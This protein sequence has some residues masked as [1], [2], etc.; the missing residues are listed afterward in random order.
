M[1]APNIKGVP[2]RD[3]A[4]F[5][6]ASRIMKSGK[7]PI[8][9]Y[10]D[11]KQIHKKEEF[12]FHKYHMEADLMRKTFGLGRSSF[13]AAMQKARLEQSL[14]KGVP[15]NQL[16]YNPLTILDNQENERDPLFG[17]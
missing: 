13:E 16:H 12:D 3:V 9:Y 1:A 5:V 2:T 7:Y 10:H 15:A 6:D 14:R 8:S 4:N 11:G 17:L